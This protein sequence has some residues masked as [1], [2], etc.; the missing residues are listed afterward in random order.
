MCRQLL[1]NIVVKYLKKKAFQKRCPF[2]NKIENINLIA[3]NP[4]FIEFLFEYVYVTQLT[5]WCLFWD[6]DWDIT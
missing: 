6:G 5:R 1:T 2:W 3:G 4:A